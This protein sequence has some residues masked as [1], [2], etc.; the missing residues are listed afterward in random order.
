MIWF[1]RRGL[2]KDPMP[3]RN[4]R[5]RTIRSP[6]QFDLGERRNG[7]IMMR[8]AQKSA[9]ERASDRRRILKLMALTPWMPC[10]GFARALADEKAAPAGIGAGT[11]VAAAEAIGTSLPRTDKPQALPAEELKPASNSL[12][13]ALRIITDARRSI[14]E[15]RDYECE[16]VKQ[17]RIGASLLKPQVIR[18]K[19]RTKPQCIYLSF[20]TV[21]K[22]REA[23]YHPARFAEKIIAHEG[24]WK[25]YV[26]GTMHLDPQGRMAMSDNRHPVTQAGLDKMITRIYENWH[27]HLQPQ[28]VEK[29]ERGVVME[30]RSTTFVQ[31]RHGRKEDEFEYHIVQLYF[32]DQHRLPVRFVGYGWPHASDEAPPLLEDYR[33]RNLKLNV[34]LGENDFDPRNPA[35]DFD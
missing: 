22:G 26:A 6:S 1:E 10:A 24:G 28:H 3:I 25:G 34:G 18:M 5:C 29:I 20:Q 27:N 7:A 13:E 31:T 17:E 11:K 19:A 14:S 35:Y 32:D 4:E 33:F 12:E 15:V 8:H 30:N 23:I 2:R 16:F 21:H 9:M